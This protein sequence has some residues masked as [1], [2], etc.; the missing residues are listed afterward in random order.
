M[1]KIVQ[2]YTHLYDEESHKHTTVAL[3]VVTIDGNT[4]EF[5]TR[6]GN[7][8][9]AER[10]FI[11]ELKY[12]IKSLNLT[13]DQ[14]KV[15][16]NLLISRSPCFVCREILEDCFQL[17]TYAGANISFTLRIAD[18]YS[19]EEGGKDNTV[20]ELASWLSLLKGE[21]IVETC[22]LEPILATNE[23]PHNISY[24]RNMFEYRKTKDDQIMH[25]VWKINQKMLKLSTD[26][27]EIAPEIKRKLYESPAVY[28]AVARVEIYAENMSKRDKFKAFKI[29]QE[30]GND[31]GQQH[32]QCC[33]TISKIIQSI[34]ELKVPES[35]NI[36][37]RNTTLT[38]TDFP[39][40]DCLAK[41]T[42]DFEEIDLLILR[43]ANIPYDRNI[44]VDWLYELHLNK[45]TVQLQ[46]V[47]VIEEVGTV[48]CKQN[49]SQAQQ[50]RN[51][52]ERRR[53]LDD[54]VVENV[55][56]INDALIIKKR[57]FD[58]EWK[59]FAG[60]LLDD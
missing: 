3:G 41:I 4:E 26:L 37:S 16:I 50:R 10:I 23:V 5:Y 11:Y 38:V 60:I 40:D 17:L 59:R 13:Q 22:D 36:R 33:A 49:S 6:S 34:S 39:C 31:I 53:Q 24:T 30:Q 21:D 48:N 27:A 29:R 55:R 1:E 14:F 7:G 12:Y 2:F 18:L 54:K 57:I 35:W 19:R 32:V 25:I 58:E 44:V 28:V 56:K 8:Y 9:H 15:T 42:S 47:R 43:V 20:E 45:M 52:I 46:P 51:A